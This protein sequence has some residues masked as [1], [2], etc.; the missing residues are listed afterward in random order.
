MPMH[1]NCASAANV[2]KHFNY[3]FKVH[4]NNQNDKVHD[5]NQTDKVHDS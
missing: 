5:N 2:D 3:R 1:F 4:D